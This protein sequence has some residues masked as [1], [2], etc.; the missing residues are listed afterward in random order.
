MY[1]KTLKISFSLRAR[2]T[3][4]FVLIFGTTTLVFSVFSYYFLNK[5]LLQDFDNALY[6]YSI[7]VSQTLE[8]SKINTV[9]SNTLM[10]DEGKIF[11]FPSG[12]ALIRLRN[13]AGKVLIQSGLFGG[14][15]SN[16]E[17]ALKDISA[18]SD[19]YYETITN[20]DQIPNAEAG[21]YRLI[22]FP[23]D[24]EKLPRL[25]LQIAVPM[26][27]FETQLEQ[28]KL[29]LIFG[30]PAVLIVA[31]VAGLFVASRALSPFQE[32]IHRLEKIGVQQLS[33]RLPLP[34][35]NDEIKKLAEA[36][37]LMLERIENAFTSQEKFI[38][39]ASHQLLTP[40]TILKGEFELQKKSEPENLFIQSG[41]QEIDGLTKIIK[42]MLLLA[43][44]DSGVSELSF[45][46]IY[47]DEIIL[48]VISKIKK[49]SAAKNIQIKFD[50]K[51]LAERKKIRGEYDLLTNLF[52][53]LIENA[54]KYSTENSSVFIQVEW[55]T[56]TT[57][58]S[59]EDFGQGI[60]ENMR[61]HLF[62]RFSRADTSSK[63]KGFGLGL[64]IAQKIAELHKTQIILD[65]K[66][67]QGCLFLVKFKN[68]EPIIGNAL[69]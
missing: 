60:S 23:I 16:Y 17:Q 24:I 9:F 44:I 31:L 53:N 48:E 25:Y 57:T 1:L 42:D 21:S 19:S 33:Q 50:I 66:K 5:S 34:R 51:E 3:L 55:Q 54:I 45:S 36:L 11:P 15:K 22:T 62:K 69:D 40:L 20:I 41:L 28:L 63:S 37:N 32:I 49:L 56:D 47:L 39:D 7:D 59:V 30:L 38:A 8:I 2:L 61:P 52:M 68:I 65:D 58:F 6:N 12:N 14:F 46:E 10:A 26:A 35:S 43:R 29:I 64:A 4:L 67:T 18:G 27:T 13:S